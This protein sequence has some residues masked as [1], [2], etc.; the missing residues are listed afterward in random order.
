MSHRPR[1]GQGLKFVAPAGLDTISSSGQSSV[2]CFL[3]SPL[4]L[5]PWSP[6]GKDLWGEDVPGA[7][8]WQDKVL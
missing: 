5:I 4:C 6:L 3:S 8:S 7:L 1:Q 2:L